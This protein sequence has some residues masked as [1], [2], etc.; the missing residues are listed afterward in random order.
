M[1]PPETG[2]RYEGDNDL[3]L[4]ADLLADEHRRHV[5]YLLRE[6]ESISLDDL[7][8][9]LAGW[10]AVR[11]DDAGATSQ[12]RDRVHVRLYH[13]DLPKLRDAGFV[14]F[15]ASTGDVSL[16]SLPPS[17]DRL[18]DVALE[19]EAGTSPEAITAADVGGE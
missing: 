15:D 11:N 1:V 17:V 10:L 8:D 2:D 18:L 9:I 6:H 14:T 3:D 12:D 19:L 4:A 16:D 13:V 5:L 7:A